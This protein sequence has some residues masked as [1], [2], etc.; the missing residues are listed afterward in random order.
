MFLNEDDEQSH[1]GRNHTESKLNDLKECHKTLP[2]GHLPSDRPLQKVCVHNDM[3]S[4]I[5]S[6]ADKV[7]TLFVFDPG[8]SHEENRRVVINM[9]DKM[10]WWLASCQL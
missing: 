8:P 1:N 10:R 9:K 7:K 6:E 2:A 5:P 4:G 3:N